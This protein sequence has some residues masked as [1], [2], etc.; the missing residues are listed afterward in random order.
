MPMI[1]RSSSACVNHRVTLRISDSYF[2]CYS[3]TFMILSSLF[4]LI[5]LALATLY[6]CYATRK[7]EGNIGEAVEQ[8]EAM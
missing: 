5:S 8:I 1:F 2:N 4:S 6:I 7:C 3:S